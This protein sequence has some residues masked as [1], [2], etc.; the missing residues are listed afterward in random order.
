ME[1][2]IQGE[3]VIQFFF[4]YLDY[5]LTSPKHFFLTVKWRAINTKVSMEIKKSS[6]AT[7]FG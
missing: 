2:N 3:E 5:L 7:Y 1:T 4:N 6:D